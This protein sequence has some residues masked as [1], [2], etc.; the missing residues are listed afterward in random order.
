MKERDTPLRLV[1][2][3]EK[4][5]PGCFSAM[6]DAFNTLSGNFPDYCPLPITNAVNW[7]AAQ[8]LDHVEDGAIR[9]SEL[10]ALWGW[11]SQKVIYAFDEDL[12]S[13]LIEQTKGMDDTD[14][15]PTDILFHLPYKVTYIKFPSSFDGAE[16]IFCWIEYD[17][18]A[19]RNEF[20][21]LVA[22]KEYTGTVP[23]I[24]HLIPGATIGDCIDSTI[25]EIRKNTEKLYDFAR[26]EAEQFGID[27]D[28]LLTD[29]SLHEQIEPALIAIQ[30]C[31]YLCAINA[32]IEDIPESKPRVHRER[33]GRIMDKASE[34]AG[35]NVGIHIGASLRR[36]RNSSTQ[37]SSAGTGSKKRPH[38]RRGH[39]HHYWA[40]TKD[41]RNLILK[42]TAPTIIHPEDGDDSITVFPVR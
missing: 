2:R 40:G 11:R 27:L 24:I 26:A 9:G 32:D 38:F 36:A 33:S 5:Y 6:D 39:W 19:H 28:E 21:V 3:I 16:G 30:L 34:V 4:D 17:T 31:L 8:N 14:I 25:A 29:D 7:I 35:K 22:K 18:D 37:H 23:F 13:S 10:I 1:R 20:R 42:W 15:L 12:C 41:A